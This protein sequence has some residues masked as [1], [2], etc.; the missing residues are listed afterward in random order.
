MVIKGLKV[1]VRL[2]NCGSERTGVNELKGE[3]IN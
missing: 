2:E 1:W 3:M